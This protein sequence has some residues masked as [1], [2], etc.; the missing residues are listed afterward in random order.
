MHSDI[1]S[2]SSLAKILITWTFPTN[3][4]VFKMATFVWKPQT[5]FHPCL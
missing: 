1:F 3:K 2:I 4:F 5:N